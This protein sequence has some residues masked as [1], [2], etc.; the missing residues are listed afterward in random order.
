MLMEIAAMARSQGFRVLAWGLGSGA[1]RSPAGMVA[2]AMDSYLS[3]IGGK[4]LEAIPAGER[5]LLARMFPSLPARAAVPPGH[6]RPVT[7]HSWIHAVRRLLETLAAGEPLVV[8]VDDLHLADRETMEMVLGLISAPPQAPVLLAF[9]YRYRQAPAWLRRAAESALNLTRLPLGPLTEADLGPLLGGYV[10]PAQRRALHAL[11]GG[12]PGYL[13]ALLDSGTPG[14][15]EIGGTGHGGPDIE[16]PTQAMSAAIAAELDGLSPTAR[17]T[18]SA[19]AVRGNDFDVP[20]L[21]QVAGIG[22]AAVHAAIDE[23]AAQDLIRPVPGTGRFAFRHMLVRRVIYHDT[24]PGWRLGAHTRAARA[25]GAASA[26]AVERAPHLA[27]VAVHGDAVALRVLAGAADAVEDEYPATAAQW[28]HAALRLLPCAGITP[29]FQARLLIKLGRA[30]GAA[31]Q[32][33]QACHT[34][35]EALRVLPMPAKERVGAVTTCARLQWH[36]GRAD[37]ARVLLHAELRSVPDGDPARIAALAVEMACTELADGDPAAAHE[38]A[39]RALH[40]ADRCRGTALRIAACGLLTVTSSGTSPVSVAAGWLDEAVPQLDGL[41]DAE[42]AERPDAPLWIGW[43]ELFTGRLRGAIAHLGRA[44]TA[45]RAAKERLVVFHALVGRAHALAAAGK[46]GGAAAAADAAIEVATTL[47]SSDLRATALVLRCQVAL[48]S[49]ERDFAERHRLHEAIG[50]TSRWFGCVTLATLA[51]VRLAVGDVPGGLSLVEAAGGPALPAICPW[52]RAGWYEQ[53]TQAALD[54]GRPE[55][56]DDWALRGGALAGQLAGTGRDG[57]AMLARARV[58]AATGC[59][60][61]AITALAAAD[62]LAASG[63][64][65]D[66]ARAQEVAGAALAANGDLAGARAVLAGAQQAYEECGASVLARQLATAWQNLAQGAPAGERRTGLGIAALTNRQRQV[67]EL[68]GEGLTNREIGARL[69]VTE[70]TVEMHLS[71][72]FVKLGV[73]NRV[74]VVREFHKAIRS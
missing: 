13:A 64:A 71:Q 14:V 73:G 30:Y 56:A 43:G 15:P 29:G 54:A 65:M 5:D 9:A 57:L 50:A 19:A 53:L 70:K 28:R 62:T 25:L 38:H 22:E 61:A 23:L 52:S 60:D 58:L 69:Y 66:A 21:A 20:T 74:G 55:S 68:V 49:G 3:I 51:E 48:R 39:A 44:I 12:N 41:S 11:S 34:L 24:S 10:T 6:A 1:L 37:D 33:E 63:M 16:H 4:I 26:P 45:G 47:R 72:I 42:L 36:L 7:R 31:G 8:A 59:Q 18:A 2:D 27:R 32:H 40:A 67:A 35:H 17:L 46:L